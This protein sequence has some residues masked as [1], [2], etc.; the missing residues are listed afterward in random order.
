MPSAPGGEVATI[1]TEEV[2]P[3]DVDESVIITAHLF[4]AKVRKSCDARVTMVGSRVFASEIISPGGDLDWRR[5]DWSSLEHVPIRVPL[6]VVAS[7]HDYLDHFGLVFGCFDFGLEA[8][9]G[10][11]EPY[12]WTSLECN[13]NGQWGWLPDAEAIADAFAETLLEGWST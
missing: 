10:S 1:W 3:S 7:L 9:E 12:R 4:Q 11:D 2:D 13:P 8:Q 6:S 5:D